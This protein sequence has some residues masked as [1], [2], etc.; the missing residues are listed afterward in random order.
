MKRFL[1]CLGLVQ[2]L[3]KH[4]GYFRDWES[5]Y[6]SLSKLGSETGGPQYLVMLGSNCCPSEREPEAFHLG[7]LPGT[8]EYNWLDQGA[9]PGA[10]LGH[11][12]YHTFQTLKG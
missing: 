11:L 2:E 6:A 4:S 5:F 7:T 10:L 9:N 3:W 12:G 8:H 1:S